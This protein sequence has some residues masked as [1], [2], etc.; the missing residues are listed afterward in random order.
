MVPRTRNAT[1]GRGR[2]RGRSQGGRNARNSVS[3]TPP[4]EEATPETQTPSTINVA[5]M[6]EVLR[7]F[8]DGF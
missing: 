2:G 6:G 8:M 1:R 3:S 4:S 5:Q 7:Q